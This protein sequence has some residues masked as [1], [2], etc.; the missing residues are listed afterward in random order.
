MCL[1]LYASSPS[2]IQVESYDEMTIVN[3]IK[4]SSCGASIASDAQQCH[5]CGVWLVSVLNKRTAR[6]TLDS[7]AGEFGVQGYPPLVLGIVG[8][9]VLYT[10]GWFFEDTQYWLD[11][12][13]MLIWGVAIPVWLG[14][15]GTVWQSAHNGWLLGIVVALPIFVI[16]LIVMWV[17]R[18]QLNDDYVGIAAIFSGLV[19]AGWILGRLT[20]LLIRKA[21]IR[22]NIV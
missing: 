3:A 12:K 4:C 14:L 11:E 8:A 18:G 7:D 17:I 15:V 19:L 20:H 10:T 9:L 13:A 22:D 16:H 6:P 2:L 21:R 1:S 5:Y